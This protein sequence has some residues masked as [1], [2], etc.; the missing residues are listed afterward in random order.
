MTDSES[1]PASD[2]T[3]TTGSERDRGALDMWGRP[4]EDAVELPSV[5]TGRRSRR[6][7]DRSRRRRRRTGVIVTVII[8]LASLAGT[9]ALVVPR[10]LEENDDDVTTDVS[11]AESLA[12]DIEPGPKALFLQI[13]PRNQLIAVT[14]AVA[15]VDGGG[16]VVFAPRNTLTDVPGFG[17]DSLAEAYRLDGEDLVGL[18]IEN[19]L[20]IELDHVAVLDERSWEQLTIDLGDLEF[21]NPREVEFDDGG[22]IRV[23]RPVGLTTL[24]SDEVGAFLAEWSVDEPDLVRLL[25][26][27]VL[28]RAF[29]EEFAAVDRPVA[30]PTASLTAFID[31]LAAGDVDFRLLPVETLSGSGPGTVYALDRV[32]VDAMI[33]ELAPETILDAG[34]RIRVRLLNGV[35]TPGLSSVATEVL[36]PA[37]ARVDLRDN[38]QTF[39]HEVTQ[40]F[41]Y[42]DDQIDEAERI[43]AALGLGEVL[44]DRNTIDVVD[45]TVLL[46]RD[47]VQEYVG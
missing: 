23:S 3:I 43:R 1:D 35:G 8:L 9:A 6:R 10:L 28:W 25:R 17:L 24:A 29:L 5:G 37:G 13:D 19:L 15:S 4:G 12:A 32:E 31:L 40:I 14:V 20:G 44:K 26:H 27:D 34:Q 30:D 16:G 42:R 18:T 41:Y 47:F 2:T 38:A 45:V 21:D 33:N 46:G 39:D 36:V 11:T 22:I 7:Q